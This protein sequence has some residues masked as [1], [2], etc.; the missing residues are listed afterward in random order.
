MQKLQVIWDAVDITG[1]GRING[2]K[3][4][5]RRAFEQIVVNILPP[6]ISRKWHHCKYLHCTYSI[7]PFF[8]AR[9]HKAKFL[10]KRS[11]VNTT[12]NP[13]NGHRMA[14]P[15]KYEMITVNGSV[16]AEDD[17]LL[18]LRIVDYGT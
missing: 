4:Q 12:C 18:D 8:N 16:C 3:L 13:C 2:S 14:P 9:N 10:F 5:T 1:A 11:R 17:I 6:I 7:A 15:A